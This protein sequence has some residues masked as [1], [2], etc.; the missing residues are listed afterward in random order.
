MVASGPLSPNVKTFTS[1]TWS[2]IAIVIPAPP[3]RGGRDPGCH[4]PRRPPNRPPPSNGHKVV[5]CR[6]GDGAV[7]SEIGPWGVAMTQSFDRR[8]FMA[9]GL[10]LGA[11]AAMLGALEGEGRRRPD[12]RAGSNGV[13]NAKTGAGR[14]PHLRHRHRGVRLRPHDGALGRGRIPLRPH[15]FDPLAIVNAS[16]GVEP[17]LAQSITSNEDFTS[18]TIT[19]APRHRLPRRHAARRQRAAPQHREAGDVRLDRAG[20]RRQ[21]PASTSPARWR[22]PST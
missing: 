7:R 20:L 22:S 16:G 13:S 11:G 2:P 10:A 18:F 6:A 15:V 14:L 5:T 1:G 19:L 4:R 8:S 3:G 17:Y 12:Q 9:G 21:S